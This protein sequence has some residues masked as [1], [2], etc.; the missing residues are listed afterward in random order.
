M[1]FTDDPWESWLMRDEVSHE[2]GVAAPAVERIAE[3]RAA[4]D[5]LQ[6]LLDHPPAKG[7]N[8]MNSRVYGLG[9]WSSVRLP[10]EDVARAQDLYR[11]VYVA[12]GTG[13]TL[14]QEGLLFIIGAA[15]QPASIP[16][17]FETLNL[18]RPR[19][20]FSTKRRT[21]AIAALAYLALKSVPGAEEALAQCAQHINADIRAQ[22][23]YYWGQI[24]LVRQQAL[25]ESATEAFLTIAVNDAAFGPRFQAREL[26]REMKL[27][28][29]FDNPEGVY[30]FKVK[31]KW[32]K[33][34]YRVIELRSTQT[35]DDLHLAIQQ[36]IH[37]D[38]D[39]LYSFFMNGITHDERYRFSCP[40]EEDHPPWTHEALLGELGLVKRHKFLYYFDYGDDHEFEIE[41]TDIRPTAERRQYPRV[42]GGH[43]E[44]P[45][46]YRRGEE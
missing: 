19:D 2:A 15:R 1:S 26:L 36:A 12:G 42:V 18:S 35:L 13:S 41:V 29:P 45:E 40:Y 46:Q 7:A 21:L 5:Q 4:L 10:S 16:F 34:I 22:A 27:P 8:L 25:P 3:L 9:L 33:S 37:W 30:A 23:V 17:W 44:A 28:V 14:V 38:N 31:F 39:H 24:Y 20:S 6:D 11:R 32:A 43:G